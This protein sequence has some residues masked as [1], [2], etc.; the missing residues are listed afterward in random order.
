MEVVISEKIKDRDNFV[1]GVRKGLTIAF[2]YIPIAIA[3]GILARSN[4]IPLHIIIAMSIIVYAG[5][6]Q[7][8]AVKLIALNAGL[9][10][11]VLATFIL[12]LRHFLMSASVSQRI[13]KKTATGLLAIISFGITDES[14]SLISLSEEKVLD[15]K[16]VFG[17]N[18][19]AY[20]SWVAGTVIG[21]FM[22]TT[23]PEIIQSSMGIALYS[24]FIGLLIPALK[25]SRKVKIIAL[26]SIVISS[27]MY[28]GPS[29]VSSISDG[30][31]IIIATIT[32]AGIAAF[33]FSDKEEG[34]KR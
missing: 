6:S 15:D 5:A 17:I 34:W 31:K 28:W 13:N 10:G 12:N 24:M 11:I 18:L 8:V 20:L 23:L 32:A 9:W 33:F 19:I 27:L 21:V 30:W 1:A 26:I 7:F 25:K 2:G 14:F 29:F 4:G 22:G 16:Y 3:F